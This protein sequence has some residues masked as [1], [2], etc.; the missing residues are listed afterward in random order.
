MKR[1][2]GERGDNMKQYYLVYNVTTSTIDC[3]CGDNSKAD[4]LLQLGRTILPVGNKK[5]R[6]VSR[7][8]IKTF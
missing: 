6:N 4:F 3:W 2:Y 8:T 5:P 7:E 1:I